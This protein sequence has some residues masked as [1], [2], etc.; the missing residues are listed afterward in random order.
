M[1]S[2]TF[3]SQA[4]VSQSAASAAGTDSTDDEAE[5]ARTA[6]RDQA[7][8]DAVGELVDHGAWVGAIDRKG[9]PRR[10]RRSSTVRPGA[11]PD[12]SLGQAVAVVDREVGGMPEE[13]AGDR[14]GIIRRAGRRWLLGSYGHGAATPARTFVPHEG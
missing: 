8:L 12:T 10:A 11:M 4:E 9:P 7:R 13:V 3:W 14:V 2:P 5:I 1:Y 6:H